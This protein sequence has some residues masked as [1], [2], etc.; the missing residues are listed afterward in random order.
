ME[1]TSGGGALYELGV[2]GLDFI[3][4]MTDK[5]P[6]LLHAVTHRE[7]SDEVDLFT[8]A[9]YD[10][11]GVVAVMTCSFNTDANYYV[12]SGERGSIT[13]PVG[14]SGRKVCNYLKIHLL[15]GD[16]KYDEEFPPDNPYKAEV[17]YFARCIM[18]G[19]EPF[20]GGANSLRNMELLEQ[21]QRDSA[22]I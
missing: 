7:R 21:L 19:E 12:L 4:Y 6:V 14:I 3:R 22:A 9:V 2:Y 11:G 5:D 8:H 10:A 18:R 20:L 13:S 17:E 1:K 16:K 15:D